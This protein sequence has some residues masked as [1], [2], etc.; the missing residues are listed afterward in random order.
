MY[1]SN[2]QVG[3]FLENQLLESFRDMFTL[4]GIKAKYHNPHDY[5]FFY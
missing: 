5:A 1:I 2:I 3:I 4:N